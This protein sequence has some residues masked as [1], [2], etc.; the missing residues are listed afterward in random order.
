MTQDNS[1]WPPL[2]YARHK[3]VWIRWRDVALTMGM[4]LIFA[5]MMN[6]EFELF[7][8]SYLDTLGLDTLLL[9]FGLGE[10]GMK[11]NLAEF[12]ANLAPYMAIIVVLLAGLS[13][14][15]VHT[16]TRRYRS[17]RAA[18]PT[19]LSLASQARE[20]ALE[21]TTGHDTVALE[22][23]PRQA[24]PVDGRTLI[25]L[26]NK[27]EEAALVD[28]RG[29]RIV[30]VK[31]N[32]DGHYQIE[33]FGEPMPSFGL[34]PGPRSDGGGELLTANTSGGWKAGTGE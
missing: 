14:F 20:A 12:V 24:L 17:L 30:T 5:A 28:V 33:A 29:L 16:L 19:P 4:W 32:A 13:G 23:G 18:N 6:R 11:L 31:V 26:M 8:G 25:D 7:F 21:P 10:L 3:S 15:S 2:I 1:Q 34:I 9:R 22:V 27:Q